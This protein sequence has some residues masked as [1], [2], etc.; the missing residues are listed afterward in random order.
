MYP[1][2]SHT[3]VHPMMLHPLASIWTVIPPQRSRRC[4]TRTRWSAAMNISSLGKTCP[5][6]KTPGSHILTF[7]RPSTKP[8]SVFIAVTP[9]C[10]VLINSRSQGTACFQVPTSLPCRTRRQPQL[11]ALSLPSFL[12]LPALLSS[13]SARLHLHSPFARLATLPQLEQLSTQVVSLALLLL[14]SIRT[15][16]RLAGLSRK[17]GMV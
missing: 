10:L 14:V 9:P 7:H 16:A 5:H 11:K 17:G 4:S 13:R 15:F 1:C 2:S 6:P 8:S 12:P 3:G